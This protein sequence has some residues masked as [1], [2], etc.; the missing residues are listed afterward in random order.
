MPSTV[1]RY[2]LAYWRGVLWWPVHAAR[3]DEID[4]QEFYNP[5]PSV[6]RF[7]KDAQ[8][9]EASNRDKGL[10]FVLDMAE[11]FVVTSSET[12]DSLLNRLAEALQ[13]FD[14]TFLKQLLDLLIGNSRDRHTFFEKDDKVLYCHRLK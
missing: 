3:M 11:Y 10:A 12:R 14:R 9:R 7:I 6:S 4:M 13:G 1:E 5:P 2:R 8:R